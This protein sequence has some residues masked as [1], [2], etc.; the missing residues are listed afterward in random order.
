MPARLRRFFRDATLPV[1]T[2]ELAFL[3]VGVVI[4][5]GLAAWGIDQVVEGMFVDLE[6][7]MR[8]A[9]GLGPLSERRP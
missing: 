5:V 3:A 2:G 1:S 8:E 7:R 4:L 9:S 6:Q